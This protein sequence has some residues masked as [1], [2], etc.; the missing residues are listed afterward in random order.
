MNCNQELHDEIIKMDYIE[1]LFCDQQ[2][3]EPTTKHIPCCNKQGIINNNGTN[4]CQNCSTVDS[5]C[6]V[7]EYID[8]NVNKQKIVKR[9]IYDRKYH[10]ENII[11]ENK[12]TLS[13]HEKN[14][15]GFQRNGQN[16]ST[17]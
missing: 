4:V 14:T 5:Y 15:S 16:T 9:S 1:C 2:F 3:K 11:L 8:F 10:L 7:K 12:I 13:Y 6:I 17:D